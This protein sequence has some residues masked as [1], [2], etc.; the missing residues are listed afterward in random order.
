MT[1]PHPNPR[2]AP[3]LPPLNALR[4]FEAAAR[5]LSFKRAAA[6]LHVS[7]AAISHQIKALENHLEVQ[8]FERRNRGLALTDIARAALPKVSDGFQSLAEGVGAMRVKDATVTLSLSAAPAF[9]A[10]WL[11]P[12]LQHFIALN[13]GIEVNLSATIQ[14]VD[15]LRADARATVEPADIESRQPDMEIRFGSG[16]YP[17]FRVDKLLS[18]SLVPV[19]SP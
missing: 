11:V 6:E 9:A 5:H 8:L 4:A 15:D 18:V 2:L 16:N 7:P 1:K 14:S 10:K 3:R 12:R 19:C 17:G 13:L